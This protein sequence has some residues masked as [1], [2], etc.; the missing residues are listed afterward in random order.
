LGGDSYFS[1][2]GG[3]S[4]ARRRWVLMVWVGIAIFRGPIWG[5]VGCGV[6]RG[7]GGGGGRGVW[8]GITGHMEHKGA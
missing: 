8:R 3:R 6:R 2:I 5:T 4:G 7:G 1:A